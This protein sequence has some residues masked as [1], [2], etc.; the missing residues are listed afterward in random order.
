[1]RVSDRSLFSLILVY[2]KKSW[3]VCAFY[4][5]TTLL[6]RMIRDETGNSNIAALF[7]QEEMR[8]RER[9]V[10]VSFYTLGQFKF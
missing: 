4:V 2:F 3:A 8:E 9:E 7:Y 5:L 10:S 6:D 1:M